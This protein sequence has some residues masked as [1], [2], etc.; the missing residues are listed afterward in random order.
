MLREVKYINW[1][2]KHLRFKDIQDR[3]THTQKSTNLSKL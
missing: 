3:K 2:C 1:I